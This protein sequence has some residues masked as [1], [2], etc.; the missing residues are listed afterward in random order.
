M[1]SLKQGLVYTLERALIMNHTLW[2]ER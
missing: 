2:K 1:M